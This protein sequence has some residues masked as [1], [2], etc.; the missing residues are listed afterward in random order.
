MNVILE[1]KLAFLLP[2]LV[3]IPG[4]YTGVRTIFLFELLLGLTF[5]ISLANK[6]KLNAKFF[7]VG[8]FI[9]SVS[10]LITAFQVMV[11]GYILSLSILRIAILLLLIYFLSKRYIL[12][13]L[14]IRHG[15]IV[16]IFFAT[17]LA[18]VQ[19]VDNVMFGG[20]VSISDLVAKLFPY[21]GELDERGLDITG[22]LQLKTNSVFSPT[23]IVDGHTILAGNFFAVAAIIMLFWKKPFLFFATALIAILTFSRG[24][25]LMLG[26]GFMYWL[27][28]VKWTVRPIV[29]AKYLIWLLSCVL[30]VRYSIFWEYLNFR[31]LNTLYVFG[32]AH[33]TSGNPVDPRT[34]YVWPQF[35]SKMNEIGIHSWIIG[36]NV[37]VPTDSGIFLFFG[38]AGLFGFLIAFLIFFYGYLLS[39]KDRL[40][41]C[42]ILMI[43]IGSVV[44][45]VLQGYRLIFLFGVVV[46]VKSIMYQSDN[47]RAAWKT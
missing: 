33:E 41:L 36:G 31:I 30:F 47:G 16:A 29:F 46:L 12:C 26:V 22:G 4:F 15:L 34:T 18:Y 3:L 14:S 19:M 8:F 23:S 42:L 21:R 6:L 35:I 2:L 1:R 20:A 13:P 45:P 10:I 25:W 17:G 43:L 37:G 39:G 32:L 24:S 9:L 27:I 11:Y 5:F 28:T 44:N 38:E 40:V 7:S